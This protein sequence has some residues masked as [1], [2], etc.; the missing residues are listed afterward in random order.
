MKL[1]ERL[2]AA[3]AGFALAIVLILSLETW[4]GLTFNHRQSESSNFVHHGSIKSKDSA[5]GNP[6]H[7]RRNLQKTDSSGL[8][9]QQ[10]VE[11]QPPEVQWKSSR[12]VTIKV[13]NHINLI[14][15]SSGIQQCCI[16]QNEAKFLPRT[17]IKILYDVHDHHTLTHLVTKYRMSQQIL[18]ATLRNL[19]E[20]IIFVKKNSSN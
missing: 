5:G 1:K 9:E 3:I 13:C 20:V 19:C 4:Q 10:P 17:L 18:D 6:A 8:S 11:D 15:Y 14:S 7:Q 12:P 16:R 2:V